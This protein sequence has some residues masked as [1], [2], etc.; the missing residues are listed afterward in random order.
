[1]ATT[2]NTVSHKYSNKSK[3]VLSQQKHRQPKIKFN[4]APHGKV[5]RH[6]STVPVYEKPRTMLQVDAPSCGCCL[7]SDRVGFVLES[8]GHGGVVCSALQFGAASVQLFRKSPLAQRI[9][10]M[11]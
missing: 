5:L 2:Y 1:M 9:Y 11:R 8:D 7:S 3:T 4:T 6:L 10:G